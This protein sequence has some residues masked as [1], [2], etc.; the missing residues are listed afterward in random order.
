[1][2]AFGLLDSLL[3]DDKHVPQVH[4]VVHWPEEPPET[5]EDQ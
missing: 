4:H 5:F 3:P 2:D 1:M